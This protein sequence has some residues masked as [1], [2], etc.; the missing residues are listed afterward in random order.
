MA[1]GLPVGGSPESLTH[2]L[3]ARPVAQQAKPEAAF[4]RQPQAAAL[5]AERLAY[6]A[7][8]PYRTVGAVQSID[9]RRI[10]AAYV[11]RFQ[12]AQGGLDL[13]HR[14]LA[15]HVGIR[16][17]SRHAAERHHLDEPYRPIVLERQPCQIDDPI[18]VESANYH[19]IDLDRMQTGPVSSV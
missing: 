13:R 17:K 11:Q 16:L 4:G 10:I 8:E 14:L 3:V 7:D 15:G 19:A 9:P 6:R 18:I 5:G 1:P 12:R 2:L